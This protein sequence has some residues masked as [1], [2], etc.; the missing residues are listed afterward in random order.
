MKLKKFQTGGQID[1]AAEPA[2][3]AQEAPMQGG[4]AGAEQQVAEIAGQLLQMLLQEIQDP[5]MVA[6]VLQAALEMLAQAAQE[7]TSEA[8]VFKKGGKLAKA[9]K[10][11]GGLKVK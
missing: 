3:A 2:P 4:Q 1:P 5:N 7:G 6:M 10:A 9:K 11:C 8:P